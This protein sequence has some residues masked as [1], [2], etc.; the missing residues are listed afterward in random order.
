MDFPEHVPN[1]K[2]I[3]LLFISPIENAFKHGINNRLT[4]FVRIRLSCE[5]DKIYFYI[6]NS[7]HPKA[8]TDRI[9]S[10]I[11]V[12]NLRRRLELAYPGRH[13]YK[14]FINVQ[15]VKQQ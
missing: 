3:P 15:F 5:K 1:I 11:G 6:E 12:E 2:I 8:D 7:C 9:G 13:V 10:G 14:Q 4:S